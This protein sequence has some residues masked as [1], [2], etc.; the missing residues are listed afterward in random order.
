MRGG[1]MRKIYRD[2]CQHDIACEPRS[3]CRPARAAS[4]EGDLPA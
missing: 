2:P 3:F 4:K 1:P